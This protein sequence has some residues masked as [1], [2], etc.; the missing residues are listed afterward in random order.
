M[1]EKAQKSL[2]V[3][4][5][6]GGSM[7]ATTAQLTDCNL[8]LSNL[9]ENMNVQDRKES[10]IDLKNGSAFRVQSDGET[11]ENKDVKYPVEGSSIHFDLNTKD[12]YDFVATRGS[13]LELNMLSYRRN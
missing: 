1:L 3:S 10:I 7:E 4:M 9:I 2:S 12:T 13:E 5:N 8:A 6:N 11:R